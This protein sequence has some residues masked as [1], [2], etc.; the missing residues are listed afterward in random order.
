MV[1]NIGY[2]YSGDDF[3]AV[4][5][6]YEDGTLTDETRIVR[7]GFLALQDRNGQ[8]V[9][10]NEYTWGLNLG[11]VHY[12][13]FYNGKGN[14]EA[15][16]D[17]ERNM[18]AAY[19]Y[20]PFGKV[21]A[22]IGALDQPFQFSTKRIDALTGLVYYGYRF[23]STEPDRWTTR[24]PLGEAGGVHLYAFVGN[25]PVNW[26]DP[27]GEDPV[28]VGVGVGTSLGGP[29]GAAA[30]AA[31][32]FVGGVIVYHKVI[33]PWVESR[34]RG[35]IKPWEPL[36]PGTPKK[37]KK[38][39]EPEGKESENEQWCETR[40]EPKALGRWRKRTPATGCENICGKCF[41]AVQ[42]NS[43]MAVVWG[44]GCLACLRIRTPF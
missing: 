15:V 29:V 42:A 23:Y 1:E 6:Q 5:K 41:K 28:A 36:S 37:K 2:T 43:P 26:V 25:N 7:D 27:Y 33:K 16:F 12:S 44:S 3:L 4:I 18:A 10:R 38:K 13:Y 32:G 40:H 30:G 14:V 19:R 17:W 34:R 35:K 31:I 24:D 8:N 39:I 20:D 9:V 21:L 22:K 11:G